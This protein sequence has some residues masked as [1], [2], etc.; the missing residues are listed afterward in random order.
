MSLASAKQ[1]G[2]RRPWMARWLYGVAAVSCSSLT[3]A[4]CGGGTSPGSGSMRSNQQ[5]LACF[6]GVGARAGLFEVASGLTAVAAYLSSGDAAI[7]S[8]MPRPNFLP[9]AIRAATAGVR[10]ASFGGMMITSTADHGSV[11]ILVFGH[12]GADGG[13][14]AASSEKIAR[15]CATGEDS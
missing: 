12:E 15:L 10:K 7:V 9:K 2:L 13:V 8:K 5:I 14:P 1:N 3:L 11:L 6:K 4:S